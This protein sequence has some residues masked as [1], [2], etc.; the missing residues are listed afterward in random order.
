MRRDCAKSVFY[1]DCSEADAEWAISQLQPE[2]LIAPGRPMS[3]VVN[4]QPPGIPRYYIECLQDRALGPQ[5]QR[6]MH[7]ESPCDGVYSLPTSHSPFLSAPAA[8][9]QYCWLS[10]PTA[11]GP[12][13]IHLM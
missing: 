10:P 7:Q 8:L 2:P 11:P 6:W 1:G 12:D 5:M 4:P 9:T 3:D 13:S